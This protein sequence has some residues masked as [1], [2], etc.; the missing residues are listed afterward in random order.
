MKKDN[1]KLIPS[2]VVVFMVCNY[3][4]FF[5]FP[6]N[7]SQ[8]PFILVGTQADLREDPGTVQRL[9]ENNLEPIRTEQGHDLAHMFS[10]H[11]YIECSSFTEEGVPEIFYEAVRCVF[12]LFHNHA[13]DYVENPYITRKEKKKCAVM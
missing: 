8:A 6:M 7:L 3:F 2:V 10:A 4:C 1:T 9:K 11:K 5:I 13:S 12:K